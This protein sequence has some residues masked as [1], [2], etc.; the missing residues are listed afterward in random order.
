MSGAFTAVEEGDL[1]AVWTFSPCGDGC[2]EVTFADG[3]TAVAMVDNGQW[4][5]DELDNPTAIKCVAD[6]SQNPGTAHYSWDP[7][8]LVGET[9]ATDDSGACGA[10]PGS[11]TVGVPFNL[12]PVN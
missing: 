2:A 9:W 8:T 1:P 6:G 3:R 11:D 10:V 5:L 7:T 12:T 4:T